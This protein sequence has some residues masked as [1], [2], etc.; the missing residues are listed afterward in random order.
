MS[1]T[2]LSLPLT[3]S[4][5]CGSVKF[6]LVA[7]PKTMVVCNCANCRKVSG[8]LFEA[9]A[10]FQKSDFNLHEGGEAFVKTYAD[11]ATHTGKPL[12]RSF[13]SHCGSCLWLMTEE[14]PE[15]IVIH[16]GTIDGVER[17]FKPTRELYRKQKMPWLPDFE[18]AEVYHEDR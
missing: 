12:L 11:N 9:N 17:V 10:W 14:V 5:L 18:G 13:C 8:S 15:R 1:E 4:C 6:T 7:L 3:G 2:K 16:S